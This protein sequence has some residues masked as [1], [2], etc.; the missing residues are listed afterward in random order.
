V[1][2]RQAEGE[3]EDGDKDDRPDLSQL[4]PPGTLDNSLRPRS[5]AGT[6]PPNGAGGGVR[7]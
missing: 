6:R 5:A 1:P 4:I 7:S 2:V 3:R